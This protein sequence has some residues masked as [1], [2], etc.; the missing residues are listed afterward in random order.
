MDGRAVVLGES[1]V[2]VPKC[3]VV[4]LVGNAFMRDPQILPYMFRVWPW[5][6]PHA[7][8]A[9]VLNVPVATAIKETPTAGV[10]LAGVTKDIVHVVVPSLL[11]GEVVTS[12][13]A[14]YFVFVLVGI[15][16]WFFNKAMPEHRLR[17]ARCGGRRRRV[18]G[19]MAVNGKTCRQAVEHARLGR[20]GHCRFL[21]PRRSSR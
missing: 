4:I 8:P 17:G 5:V 13:Q 19:P 10:T 14:A 11:L 18:P 12:R 3:P 6:S 15:P 16:S 2:A 20:S 21:R 1:P 9:S 7:M